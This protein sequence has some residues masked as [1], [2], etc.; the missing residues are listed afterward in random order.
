[1]KVAVGLEN[2]PPKLPFPVLAL[3]TFDGVHLGHQE[4]IRR[5]G[6]QARESAGTSVLMTFYPHPLRILA[7]E[8]APLMLQT[9]GQR[10][11]ALQSLGVDFLWVIPFTPDVARLSHHEFAENILCGR[12][13]PQSIC[14]GRNFHFGSGRKGNFSYLQHLGAERGFAVQEVEE[15]SYH[16][17][18]VRSTGIRRL[19]LHGRVRLAGKLLGR[20]PALVGAVVHGD[21]LGSRLQFPTANLEPENELIPPAGV[22]LTVA[23]FRG[24]RQPG[25]THIGYRPTIR[26]K[27]NPPLRVETHL[28]DFSGDIYGAR[29]EVHFLARLRQEKKFSGLEALQHQIGLDCRRARRFFAAK[30]ESSSC[31]L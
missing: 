26:Q 2:C 30:G 14:V 12:L 1:M 9:F 3:G 27:G 31:S 6:Q 28:L 29:M 13:G 22:Y 20:P 8:Q 19:I 11:A 4:V 10:C 5:V 16:R 7:P 24:R 17:L 23:G 25:L 21:R 18:P 15:K